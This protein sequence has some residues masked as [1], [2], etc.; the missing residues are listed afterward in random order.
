[1]HRPISLAEISD[2]EKT[3]ME[4]L[5]EKESMRERERRINNAGEEYRV[6][7]K[8]PTHVKMAQGERE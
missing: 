6:S 7:Y 2:H 5:K 4:V 8:S 3:F 1:L